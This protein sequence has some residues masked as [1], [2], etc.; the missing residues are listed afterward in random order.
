MKTWS[1]VALLA[2]L[3]IKW[4]TCVMADSIY[5]DDPDMCSMTKRFLRF[6]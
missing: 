5:C 6:G 3:S 1:H 2:C 4:L